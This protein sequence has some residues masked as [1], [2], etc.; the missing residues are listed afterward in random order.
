MKKISAVILITAAVLAGLYMFMVKNVVPGYLGSALPDIE[1]MASGYLNG[2]IAIGGVRWDGGLSAEIDDVVVKD[3]NGKKVAVLPKTTVYLR[4]WLA[5]EKAERALSRV[6]LEQ[7]EIYL[8]MNE[9]QSWNVQNL[10]KPSGSEETPF[11]GLLEIRQGRLYLDMPC[12]SW[13]FGLNASV[14]GGAN[15][16]F[17]VDGRLQAGED[18]LDIK[19]QMT[20]SGKG[21]LQL[22]GSSLALEP[23]AAMA[24]YFGSV[25]EAGGSLKKIQV[26]YD[27]DGS[28]ARFSGRVDLAGVRGAM[29]AGEKMYKLQLDG[30]IS[31]SDS[32]LKTEDLTA[33][34]AGYK[35]HLKGSAD[36]RDIKDPFGSGSI[37]ADT[38]EYE[39]QK[40]EKLEIPFA[41]GKKAVQ[42]DKARLHYGGGSI[43][44]SGDYAVEEKT[45]TADVEFDNVHAA[46]KEKLPDP[47]QLNGR[48]ALSA[49]MQDDK[50]VLHAAA[51]TLE[52]QWRNLKISRMDMDGDYDG[53]RLNIEHFSAFADKGTLAASGTVGSDGSL[54][55][56]GRMAEFPINPFLNIAV[57]HEGKGLCSTGFAIGGTLDAPEFEGVIQLTEAE[58]MEQKISEAHGFIS[59][60][61]NIL[62]MK[63]LRAQMD[64]GTHLLNGTID[65]N[66]EEPVMDLT[67]ETNG[68]RL[69]PLVRALGENIPV[70]GNLDN[71]VE[72]RGTVSHPQVYGELHAADGSA[73]G[74][75]FSAIDGRYSYEDGL[76]TLHGFEVN[77]FFARIT[78]EGRMTPDQ[79]LDFDVDARDVD[80]AHLPIDDQDVDLEGL[81]DAHGHLSGNLAKPLFSGDVSSSEISIN[82]EKLTE[83]KG[84]MEAS[85]PEHNEFNVSFRQP[86]KDNPIDYGLYSA[87]VNINL[88]EKF[89]KGRVYTMWGDIGGIL[90]MCRQDYAVEGLMNGEINI[91]PNGK[92]SGIDIDVHADNVKVHEIDYYGMRFKGRIY[93]G[94]IYFDDVKLQEQQGVDSSGIVTVSGTVDMPGRKL[95]MAMD[96]VQANPAIV[97]A[98]MK[99]PPEIKGFMDMQVKLS[100]SFDQPVGTGVLNITNGSVAGV[101][102]DT[103]SAELNLKNDNL[104]LDKFIVTRE[105]YNVRAEGDIPID[106]FRLR[107]ERR[108]PR[109]E[110]KLA[111]N[112]DEARL[113]MLPALTDMVEWGVG[114]TKGSVTVTGTLEEPLLYGSVKIDGGS[115]KVKDIATVIDNIRLDV[116]FRGN[117]VLLNNMSAQLGKGTVS[118]DGSYALRTDARETYRLHMKAEDAEIASEIFS[119]RINSDMEIIPQRYFVPGQGR[120]GAPP[121]ESYRPLIRG[122]VRLDDVLINMPTIPEMG[123]GSS[124]FGLDVSLELGPKIHMQNPYLYDIWLAGDMHVKGSTVF[125]IIEGS[126][127]ADRGTVTYLRT[128]FKLESASLVWVEPGTFLPNVNV[129]GTARFSRY[130][131]FV[132]IKGPVEEM[133]LQVTSDPP[134]DKNTI[135]RMLTLQRDVAGGNDVTGDDIYNLMTAGLQMTVLGDVE[136]MVKQ[137]LGLDQFRIYTGKV[138]SGV[139]FESTRDRYTELTPEERKQYNVLVSKY[140]TDHFMIGYTTSF[141]SVDRTIF[142]QYDISRH[143]NIVYSRTY[144]MDNDPDDWF[145]LEYKVSF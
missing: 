80:L 102:F 34:I 144:S 132:H 36:L 140:L 35:L 33:D 69:E 127:R 103:A 82:G 117:K 108:N 71:V 28:A 65:L 84:S 143:M 44:L 122:S 142:G 48:A 42:I 75:L 116:E 4:P 139:G 32:V 145:G 119:G 115:V 10:L 114:D 8:S 94:V 41:A 25:E 99:N 109:S 14:N 11:Y 5:L 88:T 98:V 39:G 133:D 95:D 27:N 2:S 52:L 16:D 73:A 120:N 124:N 77:A 47:V 29:A 23:Y 19:G 134:L 126:I 93:R 129:E 60:K 57:G 123:E 30:S 18:A 112:L 67:L 50:T 63:D 20:M 40:I 13:E 9:A 6:E 128:P 118:F 92:G 37:T 91:S 55:I 61:G 87:N 85:G 72:L 3:R 70:T 66:G 111:V 113:G 83:I 74:N 121:P 104:H 38:L 54:A 105:A 131:I 138:R 59:L 136:M 1:K 46:D 17:A 21:R 43:T 130:N 58:I 68:V 45:L 78:L 62:A 97:T 107:E 79:G 15:P 90:R 96:A 141:D 100:G 24:A 56:S 49:R 51:D 31:A 7:P 135:I 89:M 137:T 26:M 125:P 76:L 22:S 101:G 86:H 81:V 12:G 64:Q 53:K 106:L 110:M